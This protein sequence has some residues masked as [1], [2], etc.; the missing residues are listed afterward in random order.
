VER[1]VAKIWLTCYLSERGRC[2]AAFKVSEEL[3]MAKG[4]DSRKKEDRKEATG[5]FKS[6]KVSRRQAWQDQA[7][8]E[9]DRACQRPGAR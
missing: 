5:R 1:I 9:T 2:E 3:E 4:N 6:G 7:R 8:A